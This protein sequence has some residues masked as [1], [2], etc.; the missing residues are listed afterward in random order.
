MFMIHRKEENCE[1]LMLIHSSKF[2]TDVKRLKRSPYPGNCLTRKNRWAEIL[3]I[4]LFRK[5]RQGQAMI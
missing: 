3:I 4:Q 2:C 5:Y 1:D